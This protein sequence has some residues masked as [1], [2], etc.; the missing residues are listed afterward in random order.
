MATEMTVF[1]LNITMP[2]YMESYVYFLVQIFFFISLVTSH[3]YYPVI[4]H[5]QPSWLIQINHIFTSLHFTLVLFYFFAYLENLSA[6]LLLVCSW[7]SSEKLQKW[8]RSL[9]SCRGRVILGLRVET[10]LL[11]SALCIFEM[12]IMLGHVYP[13]Q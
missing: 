8:Q 10:F 4:L 1:F 9:A 3:S 7:S 12:F 13:F 5:T 11:L 2:Q 6:V